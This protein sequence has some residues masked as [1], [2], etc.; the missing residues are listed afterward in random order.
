M[1]I[2]AFSKLWFHVLIWVAMFIYFFTAPELF[3]VAFTKFG[4]PIRIDAQIPGES[5]QITLVVEQLEADVK[6]DQNLSSLDGWA[7][8][9][10]PDEE[11][12]DIFAREITLAS[13]E[14][15]YFFS[16]ESGLREPGEQSY[17]IDRGIDLKTLG[18]HALITDDAIQPGIY[19]IG[20][21]FRNTSTGSA[22]YSDKP[23]SYLVKTPNTLRLEKK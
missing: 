13:G 7:F 1:S 3:T 6:N 15:V 14:K 22:Y 8:I 23:A 16:V 19:R 9:I 11:K 4:K 18:F 20:I 2:K 12:A 5:D 21:V 10:P 17:F